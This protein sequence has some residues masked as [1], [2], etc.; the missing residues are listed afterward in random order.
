[1]FYATE[2]GG[3]RSYL[4]AKARWLA[5]RSRIE[6][7]IVSPSIRAAEHDQAVLAI[8]GL[9]IPGIRG[10]RLPLSI[11]SAYRA[12]ERLQPD[13]IEV[14]DA[15]TCAWA[16]LRMKRRHHIPLVAFYHSDM[17]HLIGCRFGSLAQQ[18]AQAYLR[19]VYQKFDMV[20]APSNLMV[21]QL[22]A[23]GLN[24]VRHQPLG[25]DTWVFC[26]QRRDATLRAQLRLP[27]NTRLL[28]YAGRFSPEK[29]LLLAIEAVR[30]LGKPYHLILIGSGEELPRTRQTTYIPFMRDPRLLAQLISSCDVLL[31][32]GDCET[33]GLVILEAMACG[34]PIVGTSAGGVGELVSEQTGILVPPNSAASLSE[35]IEAVFRTDLVQMGNNARQIATSQYAWDR[36]VPQLLRLYAGLLATNQREELE[37]EAGIAYGAK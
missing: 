15:S 28:V 37:A 19:H 25:V 21:Q 35:G 22:H 12:L 13:L 36:I 30:K 8:P 2:G 14:G 3:V 5:R 10:Y 6:H 34:L 7:T 24:N 1:M 4:N 9:P 26:P 27:P 20:L 31:H 11:G 17:Q 33:F 32:P 29:K 23:M 16:A 18:A